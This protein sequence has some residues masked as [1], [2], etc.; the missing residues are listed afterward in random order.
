MSHPT[1]ITSDA[2]FVLAKRLG[3]KICLGYCQKKQVTPG[4]SQTTLSGRCAE[5]FDLRR[6]LHGFSVFRQ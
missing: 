2:W 5:S 4:G 3:H 6:Q 1:R